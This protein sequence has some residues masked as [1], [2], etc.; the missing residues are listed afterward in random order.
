MILTYGVGFN[1]LASY[2]LQSTFS[3][4]SFY[5]KNILEDIFLNTTSSKVVIFVMNCEENMLNN[6][7]NTDYQNVKFLYRPLANSYIKAL[8]RLYS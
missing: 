8:L 2:N 4:Y 7:Y 6:F 3:A 5:N 1:M